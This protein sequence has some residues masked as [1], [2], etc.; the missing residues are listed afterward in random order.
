MRLCWLFEKYP[1]L[2]DRARRGELRFGTLDTWLTWKFTG[3]AEF[4]SEYSNASSTGLYDPFTLCWSGFVCG[5]LDIPMQIFPPVRDTNGDFGRCEPSLFGAA[6]PIRAAAGDQQAAMFGQG[7]FDVGDVKL[8]LGT[9]AFMDLNV[10]R[11]AHASVNGFYPVIG[12]KLVGEPAVHLAEGSANTCGGAIEWLRKQLRFVERPAEVDALAASVAASDNLYFVPA[13]N[14]LQ[15]PIMDYSACGALLGVTQQHTPGHIA[16][17]VLESLAFRNSQ[18]FESLL[19]E[20]TRT[21]P[22][23]PRRRFVVDGGVAGSDFI[24]SLTSDLIG[25]K[26]ERRANAEMSSLGVA[27]LAGLG[28][29]VWTSEAQLQALIDTDRTFEPRE[30]SRERYQPVFRK[31]REATK[32]AMHWY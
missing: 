32:R 28:A 20:T 10:G 6:I 23:N 7:C 5:L 17:A 16:R 30:G 22:D 12:W 13:F 26:I 4:A 15:A 8:T 18:I 25:R 29:G 2:K 9:G 14:G 3:G 11:S 19:N 31:W 1:T 21:V 27:F 24:V